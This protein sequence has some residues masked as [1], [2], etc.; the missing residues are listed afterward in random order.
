M[1]LLQSMCDGPVTIVSGL[2]AG[3]KSLS[4]RSLVQSLSNESA[5]MSSGLFPF[6]AGFQK[7]YVL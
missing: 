4:I 3:I 1:K 2:G 7:K 5:H 6:Q